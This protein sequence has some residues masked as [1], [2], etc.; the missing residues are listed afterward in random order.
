MSDI[1]PITSEVDA[2]GV[3]VMVG[4]RA[5]HHHAEKFGVAIQV[6]FFTYTIRPDHYEFL[7]T[8][9]LCESSVRRN[10][11]FGAAKTVQVEH[12]RDRSGFVDCGRHVRK[13]GSLLTAEEHFS[14]WISHRDF[15][16]TNASDQPSR[17][18]HLGKDTCPCDNFFQVVMLSQKRCM[19]TLVK[20]TGGQVGRMN[21]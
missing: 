18:M 14:L 12:Q 13:P 10:M 8:R 11:L 17:R 7:R 6:P 20:D 9:H 4:C 16:H 21:E 2:A 5:R 1:Q 15:D 19:R 3:N